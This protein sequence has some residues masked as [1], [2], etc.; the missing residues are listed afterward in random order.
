M[1]RIGH[2]AQEE[3]LLAV[4][5]LAGPRHSFAEI[6]VGAV[7][8]LCLGDPVA[9]EDGIGV[10]VF[11]PGR[12]ARLADSSPTVNEGGVKP[13]VGGSQ[14]PGVSQVP[15][16]EQAGVVASLVQA[17]GNGRLAGIEQ[18]ATAVGVDGAGAVVV[19]AGHQ[20]GA[21]RGTHGAHIEIR[22]PGAGAGQPVQVRRADHRVAMEAKVSPA[23]VI[24][25][26]QHHVGSGGHGGRKRTQQG[27]DH[28]QEPATQEGTHRGPGG[29]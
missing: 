16:A 1:G 5:R 21:G 13:A 29:V 23:L 14:G 24:G 10:L 2:E 3:R 27:H 26:D 12:I 19:P 11:G 9:E 25:H 22:E 8:V 18:G 7:P 15:L 28:K 17:L 20:R 4:D 6:D